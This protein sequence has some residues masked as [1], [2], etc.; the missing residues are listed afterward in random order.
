MAVSA[1]PAEKLSLASLVFSVVVFVTTLLVGRWSGFFGVF[2]AG[3]LVLSA[4]LIWCLLTVQFH[5]RSLAEQERLDMGRLAESKKASAIFEGKREHTAL[6]AVAQQRLGLLEKWFLPSFSGVIAVYQLGIGLYLLK[7]VSALGDIE[8]QEPLLCAIIMT[9][10]AFLSFLLSRYAIGMAGQD[11][12]KPLRAGGSMLLGVAILSFSLALGLALVHFGI[13][14]A[15]S[16]INF[17]IPV[18]LIV[19]GVE[20]ALNAV[21]DIYRPR[22]KLRYGRSAFDSR[23]LGIISEP[24]EIFRTAAEAIDYQFGFKVSQTWLYKLLEKAIIPLIFFGVVTLYLLSSIV[25][26]GPNEEAVIEHFGNPLSESGQIRVV[27]PGLVG[28]WP[29]PF[30]KVYKYP[31]KMVSELS[32]GFVPEIDPKTGYHRRQPT[33][34]G[35]AHYQHEDNFLIATRQVGSGS[36]DVAV[37]VGLMVAAVPVQYRV[38]DLYSFIYNNKEP[39]KLLECI[40]YRE[41]TNVAASAVVEV[42]SEADMQKSLLSMGR[43]AARRILQER[44]QI[45]ADRVGLGVEIVFIGLRG[46]HPPVEVAKDFQEFVGAV[47]KKQALILAA[48]AQ[49]NRVLSSLAGS[50]ERAEQ[51]YKLLQ[52]YQS[53]RQNAQ[54]AEMEKFDDSLDTAFSLASGDIFTTLREARSYA[55][56]KATL[57]NATGQR[58]IDQLKAY[59]AGRRI[60]QQL[61]RLVVLEQALQNVRKYIVVADK[62]DTEVFIVDVQEKLAPSLYEIGGFEETSRK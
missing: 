17:V 47:Q 19:L 23:L 61:E 34:W 43:A 35:Q 58:F 14:I 52:K 21:L 7:V 27:G 2:A 15:V 9:T 28:K 55:F 60:Y 50:V 3:W 48:Q 13:P 25:V 39:E 12:W 54:P 22:L 37:P 18:L 33:L 20:T 10:I 57:A 26:V 32:I 45:A 16:V 36:G 42:D 8:T 24:R 62:D 51:L 5:Q 53:A 1:K 46:I 41:L 30:D 29:W 4:A 40:C 59:R 11:Q 31:T 49:H 56:E 44:I 38:K 6:F